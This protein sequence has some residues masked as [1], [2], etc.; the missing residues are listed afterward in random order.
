VAALKEQQ[1]QLL[2]QEEQQQISPQATQQQQQP[3]FA[4]TSV[5]GPLL[6]SSSQGHNT[7]K[8]MAGLGT[9]LS[10]LSFSNRDRNNVGVGVVMGAPG[11]EPNYL[12][13]EPRQP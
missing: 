11:P 4:T 5:S 6:Q 8:V 9:A 12:S 1:Q 3:A 10:G 13:T 2:Q 7:E